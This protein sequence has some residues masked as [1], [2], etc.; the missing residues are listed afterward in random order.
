[1]QIESRTEA[2]QCMMWMR[3]MEPIAAIP[4][5]NTVRY[6]IEA[7]PCDR[8]CG[9]TLEYYIYSALLILIVSTIDGKLYTGVI[10]SIILD[11]IRSTDI[12]IKKKK[13]EV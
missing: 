10:N 4:P 2:S 7:L 9:Y 8:N 12:T 11:H 3:E 5:P 1:M 6:K 13:I